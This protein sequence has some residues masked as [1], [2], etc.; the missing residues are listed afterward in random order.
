M[1]LQE[2][3]TIKYLTDNNVKGLTEVIPNEE[4]RQFFS[5]MYLAS[6]ENYKAYGYF[7]HDTCKAIISC[8]K[9]IYDASWY[10]THTF[11]SDVNVVSCLLSYCINYYESQGIYKFY[12][13]VS[14]DNSDYNLY[15]E[16]SD[17][18]RYIQV[19]ECKIP[20]KTKSFYGHYN[21]LLQERTLLN[22]DYIV[23]CNF[24]KPEYRTEIPLGG[25]I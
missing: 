14:I 8:Y 18:E 9:S 19:E 12:N 1:N 10:L 20:A 3:Y 23:N 21:F 25:N 17:K 5:S 2:N 6:L 15:W 22:K 16:P 13:L 4:L 7:E 24:L 11:Y